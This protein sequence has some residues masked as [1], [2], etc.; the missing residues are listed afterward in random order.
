[1]TYPLIGNYGIPDEDSKD[2]FG[3]A[4]FFESGCIHIKS[5]LLTCGFIISSIMTQEI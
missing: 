2:K 1:M 3:L 4:K 5:V